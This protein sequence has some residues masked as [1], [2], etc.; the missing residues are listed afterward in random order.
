MIK[1]KNG[2]VPHCILQLFHTIPRGSNLRNADFNVPVLE[3]HI[4]LNA[5]C[6]F[7]DTFYGES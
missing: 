6:V 4:T 3:K 2:L 7:L 5:H 1:V